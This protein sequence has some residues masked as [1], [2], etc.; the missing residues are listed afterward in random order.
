MV[1]VMD[2]ARVRA[3]GKDDAISQV[4]KDL[5]KSGGEN[6]RILGVTK[7]R[8]GVYVVSWHAEFHG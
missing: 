8:K 4:I 1:S 3:N 5:K 2:D 6:I 7:L